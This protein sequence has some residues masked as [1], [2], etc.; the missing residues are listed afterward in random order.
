MGRAWRERLCVLVPVNVAGL[1]MWEP[2][3]PRW[4]AEAGGAA[5]FTD[6]PLE[7][8]L[9]FN[10]PHLFLQQLREAWRWLD[11]ILYWRHPRNLHPWQ[12]CAQGFSALHLYPLC[13]SPSSLN[14]YRKCLGPSAPFTAGETE[15]Q[16]NTATHFTASHLG[17]V[18]LNT[19]LDIQSHK[20]SCGHLPR[21]KPLSVFCDHHGVDAK[22]VYLTWGH[23]FNTM[24]RM[25]RIRLNIDTDTDTVIATDRMLTHIHQHH[26]WNLRTGGKLCHSFQTWR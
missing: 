1:G 3:V 2:C 19:I 9:L 6:L 5:Q 15:A 13:L 14:Q 16:G 18:T 8:F 20:Q 23:D 10:K 12:A 25:K 26:K 21:P 11:T 17:S 22:S 24:L 4:G 7:E